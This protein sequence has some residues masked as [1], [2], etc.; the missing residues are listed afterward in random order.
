MTF[1]LSLKG[2]ATGFI[3]RDIVFSETIERREKNEIY[4]SRFKISSVLF[5]FF[6]VNNFGIQT[7]LAICISGLYQ[8]KMYL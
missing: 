8:N 7:A 2:V 1:W 4:T 6:V 3:E 5:L